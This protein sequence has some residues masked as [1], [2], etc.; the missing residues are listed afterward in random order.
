MN[1]LSK[2]LRTFNLILR[3]L[4]LQQGTDARRKPFCLQKN[5]IND[6]FMFT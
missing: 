1:E 2:K 6:G 3:T 5:S 4:S